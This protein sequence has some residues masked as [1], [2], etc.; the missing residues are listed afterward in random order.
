MRGSVP[1]DTRV[2]PS[3]AIPQSPSHSDAK[4]QSPVSDTRLLTCSQTTA[5]HTTRRVRAGWCAGRGGRGPWLWKASKALCSC[6]HRSS[7]RRM[8]PGSQASHRCAHQGASLLRQASLV[9]SIIIQQE[10]CGPPCATGA[11]VL[12]WKQPAA[13]HVGRCSL[14]GRGLMPVVPFVHKALHLQ[15]DRLG[16]RGNRHLETVSSNS[17]C[18]P[19]RPAGPCDL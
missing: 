10:G 11:G 16:T 15:G 14:L 18:H 7:S 5:D 2:C 8:A 19:M 13:S 6:N 17:L 4:L 3:G 1:S 9:Y 12:A